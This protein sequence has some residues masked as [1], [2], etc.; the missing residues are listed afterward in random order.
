MRNA[1]WVLAVCSLLGGCA[2]AAGSPGATVRPNPG[3][4]VLP[5]PGYGT[6]HQDQISV[7]LTSGSLRLMVTPLVESVIRVASPD[8][9][10]RLSGLAAAHRGAVKESASG[11]DSKVFLVSLFTDA[12]GV[13]FDPQ[14]LQLISGGVRIRPSTI[15]PLTPGWDS[16]RLDQQQMDQALYVFP[17]SVDLE[18][19][20]LIVQYRDRQ[21]TQ[22]RT[23]LPRI[24]DELARVR[25]RAASGG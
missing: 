16:H 22:W 25:A 19:D 2:L 12:S 5:P 3:S 6:L 17:P 4:G 1:L 18:S 7:N 14:D 15:I 10:Q 21:S 9:Y 8:T 13:G 24:R 11:A 23:V 20:D